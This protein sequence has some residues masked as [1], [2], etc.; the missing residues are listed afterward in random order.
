MD[1]VE[2]L[3]VDDDPKMVE[4]LVEILEGDGYRVE[5]F[6]EPKTALSEAKE[7]RFTIALVD[8]IMPGITGLDFLNELRK[9]RSDT[10]VIII[11]G[12]GS[13]ESA[14]EVMKA[15]AADYISKPFKINEIQNVIKRTLEEIRFEKDLPRALEA[16]G[17]GKIIKAISNPIRR[18]VV[19]LLASR[20][21]MRFTDI[22][23]T[24]D[25]DDPTKLSFHLRELK[26]SGLLRQDQDK[27]YMLTTSG[28]R[29]ARLLLELEK[30]SY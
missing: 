21:Q 27:R 12:F 16:S 6:E 1:E 9:A 30:D 3:V 5:A 11:T 19:L 10:K 20:V 29:I 15:G 28:G 26:G 23:N 2:L 13:V 17:A 8:L 18:G 7:R 14:V 4:G 24:L 22:K 25:V